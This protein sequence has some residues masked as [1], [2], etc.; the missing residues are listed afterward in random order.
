VVE[1]DA[2]QSDKPQ[3]GADSFLVTA[4]K[5]EL[6]KGG[7]AIRGIS[8]KFSA[9][10]VTGT[11]SMSIP[12]ATSPGRGGFGPQLA[13]T[14]DSGSGNTIFGFGWSLSL[15]AITRKTDK[16]LPRYF[17]ADESDVFLIS[18]AEDLVPILD[19]GGIRH[20]DTT[21]AAGYTIHRYRP[22]IEGLFARIER[23]TKDDGDVHWRSISKDNVTTLYGLDENSRIFDPK[24]PARI[25][26]WLI[27]RSYDD[28]GNAISYRYRKEDGEGVDLTLS[29]EANRGDKS[30][31]RR[32]VNRY[33]NR[34][35]YGNVSPYFA[36]VLGGRTI[37]AAWPTKWMFE[38]VF[39]YEGEEHRTGFVQDAADKREYFKD[40]ALASVSK[41]TIRKDAFSSYRAGF[42][43]RTNRR[44]SRTLMFHHFQTELGRPDYL[45]RSTDFSYEYGVE[46][47]SAA[48]A[49]YL[50]SV[51]QRA[52]EVW[53]K[54][55]HLGQYYTRAMPPVEF[56][57]TEATIDDTVREL[58]STSLEN[59][60][61]GLDGRNYQWV[62]LDSEGMS[63]IL[64]EQGGAWYYK[65]NLSPI[66]L[67]TENPN[68]STA[69]QVTL[70]QFAPLEV[71]SRLPSLANLSGGGQ[72][73][74]DLAGDGELDLVMLDR[75]MPG[76]FERTFDGSWSSFVPFQSHPELPWSSPNLK[77]VDLTGDGH[78]DILITE[79]DAF[80]W[81]ASLGEAGFAPALRVQKVLDE[82]LGPRVVFADGTDT[83]FLAD[84]SGDGLTDLGRIRNGEVCYW[85]NL[86]YG[87]FGAKVTMDAAP[88]FDYPDRFD[89]RRVRLA[90]IDGSGT[91]DIVYL[92]ADEAR[93]YYNL[94]GNAWSAAH[95]LSTF[96][97]VDNIANV[98]VLDLLG[99][100]TA[101]IAWSSPLPGNA[102]S[103]LRYIDLMG[104]Q[105]PHLLTKVV[106]N[107]GAETEIH[108]LPSTYFYLRDK[109]AGT[110][111][112]TRLP[113]PVH[114]VDKVTVRDKWQG[115][116]FSSTYSYHH[117]YFDGVEREFRGFGRYE[118]IDTQAYPKVAAA[119]AGS[120]YVTQDLTLW[121]PPVKSVT[122]MH[123]GV[124]ADR[125]R[126]LGLFED[127]YFPNRFAARLTHS[128]FAEKQL[129]QPSIDKGLA[130]SPDLDA[131]EWREAMR[132]C[133]GMV[134][135]QE[136]FELDLTALHEHGEHK[137]VR[138][139]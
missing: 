29:R 138:L 71:V 89:P 135:R 8:E 113:F 76:F 123:T 22:R 80:C 69:H 72:Q 66:N 82:E 36:T 49:S 32:G 111:W 60:P 34:I 12:I 38:L 90:D 134:L 85:P 59:M 61:S 75:P 87:R 15:P 119:N 115:T 95:V 47:G 94:A 122:W 118:Q 19:S 2:R 107:L 18:G 7:G 136:V 130:A 54:G 109:M 92:H 137:P 26:S 73:L 31:V 117:G 58:D 100:G 50:R 70:A 11:G 33:P 114:C 51:A 96:P 57:Y 88:W 68:T 86:G 10:P 103:P 133:K 121:Q 78:A 99:N 37:S 101:C 53:D 42:E 81:Y 3:G 17:D 5:L 35:L 13:L 91:T 25:F 129:P 79:D 39:E 110:P 45:V 93:I 30:D 104:S 55:T 84:L 16:G 56:A 77:F 127:E 28:K 23:W 41:W 112:A 102:R 83:I 98:Q 74:L 21:A 126:I 4:P 108:Y 44:C 106:N 97:R 65:R 24:Q 48:V 1:R 124:A 20:V 64:A 116:E 131:D 52:Y 125:A 67:K 132:A 120:P 9:N 128:Q 139:Y 27:C 14:Y 46:D 40:A 105:K 43:V 6:P 62:D 63:G